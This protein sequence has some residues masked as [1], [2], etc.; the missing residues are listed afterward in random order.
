MVEIVELTK[1]VLTVSHQQLI[2]YVNTIY[3]AFE[4]VAEEFSG[5]QTLRMNDQMY[6]GILGIEGNVDK[7]EQVAQAVDFCL[8]MNVEIDRIGSGLELGLPLRMVV[9]SGGPVIF[10]PLSSDVP[11]L[12]VFGPLVPETRA[13]LADGPPGVVQVGRSLVGLFIDGE[14]RVREEQ[15]VSNRI[16][17]AERVA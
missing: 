13:M 5:L 4:Q 11:M 3:D 9:N 14:F 1:A 2:S 8:K 10:G 12:D 17:V 16:M 15:G 6:I 7:G